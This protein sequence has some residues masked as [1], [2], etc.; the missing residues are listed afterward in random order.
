[1]RFAWY[2]LAVAICCVPVACKQRNGTI[3]IGGGDGSTSE[4][5]LIGSWG[6]GPGVYR[7][8]DFR[9]DHTATVTFKDP[10]GLFEVAAE[11]KC[12]DI[13]LLEICYKVTQP[14]RTRYAGAVRA[15]KPTDLPPELPDVGQYEFDLPGKKHYT[16]ELRVRTTGPLADQKVL[17]MLKGLWKP[18]DLAKEKK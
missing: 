13:G 7:R 3:Y 10:E 9:D 18:E 4:R 6:K 11:W 2:F 1:M 5:S 12:P 16:E 14:Q 15:Q 8:I 17:F